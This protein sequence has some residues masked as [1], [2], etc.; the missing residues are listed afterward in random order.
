MTFTG[1]PNPDGSRR[2][3]QTCGHPTVEVTSGTGTER[4]HCGTFEARCH[5][6]TA[7]RR[8]R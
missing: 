4:V 2:D 1:I 3:C 8:T 6:T 5:T 7:R